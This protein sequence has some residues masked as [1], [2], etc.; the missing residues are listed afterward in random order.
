MDVKSQ[1]LAGDEPTT[2]R[3]YIPLTK[4][5]ISLL[6]VVTVVPAMLFTASGLPSV[7]TALAALVGTFLASASAAVFNHL[8]DADLDMVMNRTS[9][10]PMPSGK[11]TNTNAFIFGLTLG[12]LSTSILLAYT[13]PLA[14]IVAIAANLFYVLI[15]T[16][17]LKRNTD[18]NIVIGGAAGAVGPLIGWAAVTGELSWQAWILFLIIFLWTPPHFWALAIKYRDDYAAANVPMLPVTRG[19]EVTRRHIFLYTLTLVP[20]VA[21]LYVS[22][23]A[24]LVYLIGAMG[25]TIYFV[26]KAW[27]LYRDHH[28]EKAMAVF[29][30][31]CLYLFIVF[32]A[33]TLDRLVRIF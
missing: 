7:T 1:I 29:H 12:I 3:D 30:Y 23:D 33:L 24:G 28:N 14:A 26:Y 4:P 10:R 20:A 15:Y 21:S 25:A 9:K 8:L 16:Y 32:G 17:G 22:N 11:V 13:T 19:F 31:S 6:V 27:Q 18:Q 5:T 2:W